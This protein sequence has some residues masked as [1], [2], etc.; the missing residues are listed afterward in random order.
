MRDEVK[1]ILANLTGTHH[2]VIALLYGT[3]MRLSEGLRLRVKDID[4]DYRQ[5]TVPDGKG[6]KDR[7]MMLPT[8]LI[9]GLQMQLARAKASIPCVTALQPTS[10]KTA[11]TFEPYRSLWGIAM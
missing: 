5:I 9:S 10:W 6:G 7:L 11:T 2:L 3:G 8:S 1:R 4:F